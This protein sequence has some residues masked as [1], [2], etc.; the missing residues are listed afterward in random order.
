MPSYEYGFFIDLFHKVDAIP[1]HIE[2][3]CDPAIP[4]KDTALSIGTALIAHLI[5]HCRG[6]ATT[7][8]QPLL[9]FISPVWIL[10]MSYDFC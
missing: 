10:I 9:G 8:P 4:P 5:T 7:P 6:L 3:D 1:Y 2:E